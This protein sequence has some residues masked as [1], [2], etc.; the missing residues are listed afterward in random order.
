VSPVFHHRVHDHEELFAC[1]LPGL[2]S[3][4]QP[5]RPTGHKTLEFLVVLSGPIGLS[6]RGGF[7]LTRD[8]P[9]SCTLHDLFISSESR[10]PVVHHFMVG[11][12]GSVAGPTHERTIPVVE[13][14]AASWIRGTP[15]LGSRGPTTLLRESATLSGLLSEEIRG[16]GVIG[17]VVAVCVRGHLNGLL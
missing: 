16:S 6:Y 8:C 14:P 13:V 7:G 17:R 11:R 10:T 3:C 15:T 5:N 2:S 1:R 12:L 9:G 4:L